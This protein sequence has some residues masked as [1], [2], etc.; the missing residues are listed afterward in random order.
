MNMPAPD[1]PRPFKLRIEDFQLLDRAGAFDGARVEMV[2]GLVVAM[3]AE[4]LPHGPTP[5]P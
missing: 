3:D 2:E 4:M 1:A 5:Y